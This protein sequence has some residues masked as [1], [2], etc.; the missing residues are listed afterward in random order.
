MIEGWRQDKPPGVERSADRLLMAITNG[1]RE[2]EV[3]LPELSAWLLDEVAAI[4]RKFDQRNGADHFAKR[5]EAR[6][7]FVLG[8]PD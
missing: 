3:P 6:W 8:A 5:I 1:K 4:G 7:P 2:G